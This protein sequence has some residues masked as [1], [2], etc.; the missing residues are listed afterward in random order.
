[1]R[2]WVSVVGK[3]DQHFAFLVGWPNPNAK[4]RSNVKWEAWLG[5][6]EPTMTTMNDRA[7]ADYT[8]FARWRGLDSADSI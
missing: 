2:A 7:I 5:V 6:R 3:G 8:A 1:M 4:V